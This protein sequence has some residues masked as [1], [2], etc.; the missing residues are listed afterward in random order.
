MSTFE[1]ATLFKTLCILVRFQQTEPN[2]NRGIW[3]KTEPKPTET[4]RGETV[5]AL[6]AMESG[7]VAGERLYLQTDMYNFCPELVRSVKCRCLQ[8]ALRA[9]SMV[10]S[11]SVWLAQLV[12][13]LA[14]PTHVRSCVQEVRFDPRSGQA[15]LWL[16]DHYRR[17]RRLKRAAVE[18]V[19]C[20]LCSRRRKLLHVAP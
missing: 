10:C 4:A 8:H 18:M 19:M 14:A 2:R 20:G 11:M 9:Y 12:R 17:L 3:P 15:W 16:G 1:S 13:A 5:T 6:L 7:V